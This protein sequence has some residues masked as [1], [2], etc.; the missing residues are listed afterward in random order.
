MVKGTLLTGTLS[1]VKVAIEGE[2][3]IAI[4]SG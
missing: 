1:G 3:K 2:D 4:L